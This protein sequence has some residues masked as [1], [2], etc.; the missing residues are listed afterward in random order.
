MTNKLA[1]IAAAN[2]IAFALCSAARGQGVPL[3]GEGAQLG[4]IAV[5]VAGDNGDPLTVPVDIRLTP[6]VFGSPIPVFPRQIGRGWIFENV[7]AGNSYDLDVEAKGYQ[8]DHETISLPDLAGTTQSFIVYL[9]PID[10]KLVFHPPEGQFT[11]PPKAG[12]EVQKGLKDF[13]SHNFKGGQKH[14]SKALLLSPDNPYVNYVAGVGYLLNRQVAAARPYL[15]K[16]VSID[17]GEAPALVALGNLRFQEKDYTGAERVLKRAVELDPKSWKSRWVLADCYLHEEDFQGAREQASQALESGG[18]KASQARVVLG[19]ALAELGD[20]DGARSAM[21]TFLREN[22]RYPNAPAIRS[23]LAELGKTPQPVAERTSGAVASSQ[24]V[25]IKTVASSSAVL[26]AAPKISASLISPP[27]LSPELPPNEDWAPKDIDAESPFVISGVACALPKVLESA[28]KYTEKLVK[29]LQ[30]FTAMEHTEIVEVKRDKSLETPQARTADYMV[31][32]DHS[33]HKSI[34]VQE[35]RRPPV[36]PSDVP[37]GIVDIGAPA[38]VFAFHP[39]YRDSYNWSCDGLGEWKDRPA[40]IVRFSQKSAGPASLLSTFETRARRYILPLKGRAWVAANGGQIMHL[41]T[42]LVKPVTAIALRKQ[43]FVVDYTPVAFRT[44]KVTLWLPSDVNL[45]LHYG[46][47][48]LHYY[49]HYSKFSLFW[50]GTSEK[51]EQPKE[52]KKGN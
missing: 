50:V 6:Q 37:G 25:A 4:T 1:V 18:Q 36:L 13:Q 32:L 22:P 5:Y 17:S 26:P 41:E 44:H 9:K 34:Q 24:P 47:H 30:D 48:Y 2:I 16:S 27:P 11:L 14:L 38:L 3:P 42:D 51:D 8:P 10:E 49:H 52:T 39:I 28:S 21:E 20:F 15:E 46:K 33:D 35:L 12:K 40:W 31:V 29:N 45:Y 23:W 43:H 7:P 19:E